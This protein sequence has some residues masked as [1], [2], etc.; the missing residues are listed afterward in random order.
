MVS[1]ASPGYAM[2]FTP[3]TGISSRVSR[4]LLK[5]NL[6][7]NA[8]TQCAFGAGIANYMA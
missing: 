4:K 1:I 3:S 8:V 6:G 7:V 5:T 2:L